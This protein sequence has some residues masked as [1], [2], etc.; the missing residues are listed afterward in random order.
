VDR[1]VASEDLSARRLYAPELPAE[2]NVVCL[3]AIAAGH[4]RVL[5]LVAGDE[6]E[7]FDGR[8]ARVRA[9]LED[10]KRARARTLTTPVLTAPPPFV[11]LVLCMPK[12]HKVD[13]IVRMTTELGVRAI[14]LALSEQSARLNR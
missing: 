9:I 4:A 14:V 7:L 6:V 3:D 2:P 10:A 13:D 8:G 1:T 11:G 12:G 5:R